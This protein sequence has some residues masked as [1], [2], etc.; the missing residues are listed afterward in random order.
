[1]NHI[2]RRGERPFAPTAWPIYLKIAGNEVAAK[3][4]RPD[5]VMSTIFSGFC[6]GGSLTM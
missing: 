6:Y 1:M 2:C 5:S 3:G 4:D